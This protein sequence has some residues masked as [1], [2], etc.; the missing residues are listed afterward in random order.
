M[1]WI[2]G[3]RFRGTTSL[4]DEAAAAGRAAVVLDV[5]VPFGVGFVAFDV[6]S[7]TGVEVAAVVECVADSAFAGKIA[8]VAAM[9]LN[10]VPDATRIWQFE[11]RRRKPWRQR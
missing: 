10:T 5:A 7:E 4:P 6:V 8:T 9:P 1:A 11:L 3:R 2:W